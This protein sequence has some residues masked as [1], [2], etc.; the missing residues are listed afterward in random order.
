[1]VG[2]GNRLV[3]PPTC[4]ANGPWGPPVALLLGAIPAARPR[5][6]NPRDAVHAPILVRHRVPADRPVQ[7]RIDRIRGR[8]DPNRVSVVPGGGARE[9]LRKAGGAIHREK[10][11][12]ILRRLMKAAALERAAGIGEAET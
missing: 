11:R 4:L 7:P 3:L 2:Y 12:E 1:M 5:G 10:V 9:R 8:R 6:P